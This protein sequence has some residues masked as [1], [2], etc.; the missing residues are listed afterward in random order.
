MV[1]AMVDGQTVMAERLVGKYMNLLPKQL[2]LDRMQSI[3]KSI[4]D[5]LLSNPTNSKSILKNIALVTGT[6]VINHKLGTPLQGWTPIRYHGAW[7][8]IYD[9]QDANQM[10]QLTLVLVASAPV[11]IDLEVF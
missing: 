10:P 6:N 8:Q 5:P 9:T 1:L 3:W 2:P 4:I 11:T 7:A